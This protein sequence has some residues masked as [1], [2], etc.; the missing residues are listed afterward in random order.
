MKN[1]ANQKNNQKGHIVERTSE[2][3]SR[4]R[5]KKM[6]I[7]GCINDF[8]LAFGESYRV[9][10]DG[11]HDYQVAADTENTVFVGLIEWTKEL[12]KGIIQTRYKKGFIVPFTNNDPIT[13]EPVQS[14]N[15]V[16]HH[17]IIF[18]IENPNEFERM[19]NKKAK[20]AKGKIGKYPK[21][22]KNDFRDIIQKKIEKEYKAKTSG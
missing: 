12:K 19:F 15:E 1:L 17:M 11:N 7:T 3:A 8:H 22:S 18:M 20:P 9:M 10:T 13:R 21:I 16:I 2:M 4:E 5:L 6:K 14:I